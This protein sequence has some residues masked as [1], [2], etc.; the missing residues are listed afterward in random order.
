MQEQCRSES[1]DENGALTLHVRAGYADNSALK[2]FRKER[3][4]L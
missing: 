4:P 2:L 3:Y 1:T